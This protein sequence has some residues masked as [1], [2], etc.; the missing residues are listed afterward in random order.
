LR[1]TS[2]VCVENIYSS[3]LR[4]GCM[5]AVKVILMLAQLLMLY[6]G[7]ARFDSLPRRNFEAG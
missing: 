5:S 1:R 7:S 3:E 6:I 4:I 2:L